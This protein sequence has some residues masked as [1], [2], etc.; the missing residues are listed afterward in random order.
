MIPFTGH[1]AVRQYVRGKPNPTGLK[2]FV[3]ASSCGEVLDFEIFQGKDA[4]PDANTIQL[5]IGGLAVLRLIQTVPPNTSLFVDRYFTSVQ[6]QD[7]LLEKRITVTGTIMKNLV[8]KEAKPMLKSADKMKKE[9]RGSINQLVREDKNICIIQWFD[10]KEVLTASS[11]FG[12][13]PVDVCR[14]WSKADNAYIDVQHPALIKQY[15]DKMGGVDLSDRMIS[16]YRMCARTKKWTVRTILHMIDLC[17]ANSWVQ[18]REERITEGKTKKELAE[19]LD[20]RLSVSESLLFWEDLSEDEDD[21][22]FGPGDEPL[23]KRIALPVEVARR[24]R[25]DHM[26]RMMSDMKNAARCRN[27]PCKTGKSR[28]MCA[29]CKVFLCIRGCFEEFHR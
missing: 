5:S 25:A 28:V 26:P 27:P 23:P 21:G 20:F 14:R 4:F 19:F 29:T 15:N 16:Y 22:D 18:E 10:N 24:H 2:N 7:A 12:S 3:L 11:E 17:L 1:V 13:D 9:G 8:P 6:L